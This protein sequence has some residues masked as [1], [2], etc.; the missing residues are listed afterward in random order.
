MS[1]TASELLVRVREQTK[2]KRTGSEDCT[3][4]EPAMSARCLDLAG[5]SR[6]FQTS[7]GP[8]TLRDS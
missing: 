6:Q 7:V 2:M 1:K 4:T 5:A 3:S 8:R